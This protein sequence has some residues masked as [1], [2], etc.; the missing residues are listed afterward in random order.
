MIRPIVMRGLSDEIGSWKTIWIRLRKSRSFR[1]EIAVR[2]VSSIRT[3]PSSTRSSPRLTR[4]S[5]DLPQPDS[6]TRPSV[7]PG[8]IVSETPSSARTTPPAPGKCR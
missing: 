1:F 4:P 2:S 5:V 7:S 8:A 6:P 3:A